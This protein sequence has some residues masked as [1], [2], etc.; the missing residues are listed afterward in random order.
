MGLLFEI[1][2]FYYIFGNALLNKNQILIPQGSKI[3]TVHSMSSLTGILAL[4]MPKLV[5][6]RSR[7]QISVFNTSLIGH[8]SITLCAS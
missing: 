3:Q 6:I 7:I 5:I 1:I 2:I 8:K 4:Q